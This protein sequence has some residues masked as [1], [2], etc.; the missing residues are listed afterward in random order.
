MLAKDLSDEFPLAR[1]IIAYADPSAAYGAD[2]KAGD[3]SWIELVAHHA[4]IRVLAAP[5]N[6][7]TPR[8]EAVRAPLSRLIDAQPG[9]LLSPRCKVLRE[10]F[11]AGYRYK[12]N[13]NDPGKFAT[14]EPD[15]NK[16]SHPQDALQYAISGG[17]ED[18]E[19]RDRRGRAA[20]GQAMR[21]HVHDWDPLSGRD[22]A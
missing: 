8:L 13:P 5:T 1:T 6:A 15:K 4:A 14:D 12:Q 3:Q 2:K 9:F 11:N 19:I 7:L 21:Q 17:G 18:A 16:Y 10:G 20:Q 22:I